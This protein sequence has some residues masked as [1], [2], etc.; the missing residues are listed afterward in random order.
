MPKALE[1]FLLFIV[2]LLTINLAF[3]GLLQLRTTANLF[4]EQSPLFCLKISM[5]IYLFWLPIFMFYG[6]YQSWYTRSRFSEFLVVF[7]S[8]SIGIF[9][10]FIVT[11]DPERDLTQAPTLGRFMILSYWLL[12]VFFVGIGRL[13]LHTFQRKL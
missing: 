10:I 2:D 13:M 6:L 12:M 9:L 3:F 5:I 4:V 8:V 11:F 1:K 7:K